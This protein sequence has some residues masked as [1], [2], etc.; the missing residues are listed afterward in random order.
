MSTARDSGDSFF[1]HEPGLFKRVCPSVRLSVHWYVHWYVCPSLMLS[2]TLKK[3]R[4]DCNNFPCL[5]ETRQ[6]AANIVYMNLFLVACTRLYT[7]LCRSVRWSFCRSVR[8]WEITL[9]LVAF[10]VLFKP[11]SKLNFI[12]APA[13]Q[14]ATVQPCIRPCSANWFISSNLPV[15][16]FE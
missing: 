2:K 14:H 16:S 10:S 6:R 5:A 7:S 1:S 11:K 9:R 8:R 13:Q 15:I 4:S 12:I 3:L